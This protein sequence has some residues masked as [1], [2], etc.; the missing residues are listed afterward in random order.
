VQVGVVATNLLDRRYRSAEYNYA[1]DF[2]SQAVP[3]ARGCTAFRR[4]RAA[5]RSSRPSR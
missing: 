5:A 3:D 1:S 2:H 4:R